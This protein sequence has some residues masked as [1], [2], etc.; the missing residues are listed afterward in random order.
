MLPSLIPRPTVQESALF[1]D[2]DSLEMLLDDLKSKHTEGPPIRIASRSP[3]LLVAPKEREKDKRGGL[4]L[5]SPLYVPERSPV[6][7][8]LIPL[9]RRAGRRT[10]MRPLRRRRRRRPLIW[11]RW[12][13]PPRKGPTPRAGNIA[14]RS[15]NFLQCRFM[16]RFC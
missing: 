12:S 5:S 8:N 1:E 9:E 7:A 13:T 11:P 3:P 2:T 4:R 15:A 10:L 16:N 6:V 14:S